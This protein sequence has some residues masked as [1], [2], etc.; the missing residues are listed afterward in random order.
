[1]PSQ[2][3]PNSG[4]TSSKLELTTVKSNQYLLMAKICIKTSTYLSSFLDLLLLPH[5]LS[6]YITSSH[7]CTYISQAKYFHFFAGHLHHIFYKRWF[8]CSHTTFPPWI[9]FPRSL[10]EYLYF[11]MAYVDVSLHHCGRRHP[12]FLQP[13]LIDVHC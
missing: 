13:A 9:L 4:T 1:M 12:A 7:D 8:H 10:I 11:R 5:F 3:R 6:P 2:F